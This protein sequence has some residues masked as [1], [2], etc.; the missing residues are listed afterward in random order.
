MKPSLSFL[1]IITLVLVGCRQKARSNFQSE[2]SAQT[3]AIDPSLKE[4]AE[5]AVITGKVL[6]RDFY[7]QEKELTLIIPFFRD[8][9]NQYRS[10][11]QEDGSFSFR[12]PVYA[13]LREVSIRN[14]AEHLYIHPGDSIYVEIDFKDLFH[15]RVTGDA[16]KLNQEIVA[17]TE[18][19]YYYMQNYNMKPEADVK[20]FEAELKKDYNFR[21]ER[22]NEY[23]VK[24]KPMKDVVL[25]TEEL[26]KQDYY[27]ALLFNGMSYLFETREE[28]DRYHTLL[29][30][31]NKL[32]TKGILSARLYDIA[33]EAE[34]YIAYGI[35]FRDKKSPSIEEIMN[36]MG[37]REMNQ[38]LYTK[39]VAGSL[40]TNDTL[41]FHE[42][43]TQF[44]S[45]VKM[46]HLRAQVMQI[47]NQTKS[48][49]KNP[50]PVSDNLLYGE[51]H[52]NSKHTTRMPYMEA[53]YDVLE[54]N[55]GKVIYFDFWARW[56]PPCLT[57]M[58]PLKQ[59]RS[60][61]STNDLIIYSICVSEPKEQWE[62]CLNEYSLKNCGI[63]CVHVTD[64]LGIDNYQKIRK[65][66]KIDRIPY[67]ILINRKGQ[68][69]DFGTTARPS[70]PQF[71]SRIEEAVKDSK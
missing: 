13:K 11:I 34:R 40:C 33:D 32:Y 55:H 31:I 17:F 71:V 24:Y 19:A 5:E 8:M 52:E 64:Y 1:I 10:P 4:Y 21:L 39:L 35:A 14:Y 56:C 46:S 66:W 61:F 9:E 38:Y 43:R 36:V 48:Y 49:L 28:M 20:E 12:F 50:Q 67:Y 42:K 68:I 26:L 6:N 22:R 57:E 15:P 62:E 27:Y 63:E 37:E 2:S 54:K 51:F 25:F 45:I 29:P 58:E 41:A 23:L 30:E 60:K 7:P 59:L 18:S 16:E 69:V 44:D 47:Y 65:Q 53:V 3:E 70:N